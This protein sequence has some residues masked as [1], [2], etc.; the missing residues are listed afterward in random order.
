MTDRNSDLA[1]IHV[2]KKQLGM[3]DD[4]YRSMLSNVAGVQSARDLTIRQRGLVLAHLRM[5]GWQP[6][7]RKRRREPGDVR[8]DNQPLMSKIGALLAD[9]S[10]EWAY[11]DGIAA[12]MFKVESVRFCSGHQLHKIVAALMYRQRAVRGSATGGDHDPA[13]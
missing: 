9:M 8:R 10:L 4:T 12:Q 3:D 11:A 5:L 13:A 7:A 1:K 2:A 6:A